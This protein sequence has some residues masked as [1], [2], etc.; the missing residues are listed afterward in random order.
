MK[1]M[2]RMK[3]RLASLKPLGCLLLVAMFVAIY[4]LA[5]A[6]AMEDERISAAADTENKEAYITELEMTSYKEEPEDTTVESTY[7]D[8]DLTDDLQDYIFDLCNEYGVDEKIVIAVIEKE[9]GYNPDA[10][11]DN[12]NSQG[13]MQIWKSCHK[14]RMKNLGVDN[15]YNPQD[16]IAVGID[17][18][19]EK[20]GKYQDTEMALIAYNTGDAGAYENYFSKGIY[21]NSYSQAVLA[22]A[23]SLQMR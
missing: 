12:G 22:I 8:V 16:N 9:S 1:N 5:S 19:A 15:L 17:V 10:T 21:S 23:G 20:L 2:K 3:H 11:A 4:S 13:L 18:L 6:D 14:D 7:Y